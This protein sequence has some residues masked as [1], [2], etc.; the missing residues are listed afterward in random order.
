MSGNVFEW[1]ADC[2]H[3]NYINAP[4]DGSVWE[5]ENGE[6]KGYITRGGSWWTSPNSIPKQSQ[7]CLRVS[8]REW[9]PCK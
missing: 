2:T 4:N 7:D 6:C 8:A 5:G 9:N 3:V 1:C